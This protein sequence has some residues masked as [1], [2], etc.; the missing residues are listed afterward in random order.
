MIAPPVEIH[1]WMEQHYHVVTQAAM[2]AAKLI[3][4][5]VKVSVR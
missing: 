4:K 3:L 1:D 5:N 2:Q